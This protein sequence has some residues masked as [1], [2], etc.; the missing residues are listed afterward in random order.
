MHAYNPENIAYDYYMICFNNNTQSLV[1]FVSF[2]LNLRL[3][4][5]FEEDLF[6]LLIDS[7]L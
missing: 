2:F 7:Q 6:D 5:L 4:L 3:V 1:Y